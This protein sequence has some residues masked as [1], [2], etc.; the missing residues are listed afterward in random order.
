VRIRSIKPEWLEDQ[1]LSGCSDTARVLSVALILLSD[2][3]GRGRASIGFIIGHVWSAQ[4]LANPRET[5]A[6]ATGALRELVAMRY[7]WLYEIDGQQYFAIRN[8][9]KH[10]RVD[11]PGKPH[12][13][14][15]LDDAR[16]T[17]AKVLDT[18]APDRDRDQEP[19]QDMDRELAPAKADDVTTV[20][21][22]FQAVRSERIPG[23]RSMK[24]DGTRRAHIRAR[25]ADYGLARCLEAITTLHDPARWWYQHDACRFE[26]LFRSSEAFEKI[27]Q[28]RPCAVAK[29]ASDL[30]VATPC[31]PESFT[32]GRLPPK[33]VS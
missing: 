28:S 19:D 30:G 12:V 22:R 4:M 10:Q 27:E 32:V 11:K 26:L 8:W 5:V 9:T 16:E 25:L 21:D 15:P 2:D 1:L 6:S 33:A 23:C 13:P 29:P 31:R 14:E 20:W 3:Y 18:L 24:L 7:V 17:P